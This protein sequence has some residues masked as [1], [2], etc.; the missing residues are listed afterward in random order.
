MS[1]KYKFRDQTVPH[2][3]TITLVQWIDLFTR[4]KYSEFLIDQFKHCQK[5]K[6]LLIY[7]WC[8]MPSHVHMII[9]T[10]D[11]D[12]QDILRDLKT[13]TSKNLYEMVKSNKQESRREWLL[14]FFREAGKMNGNNKHIQVWQQHNHPLEMRG[15]SKIQRCVDYI[16]MNPVV[17][18]YV[19]RPEN[20]KWSSA[21]NYVEGRRDGL[22]MLEELIY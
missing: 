9:G 14:R 12:M 10:C 19:L 3:I 16:H 17:A 21:R 22:I 6:G 2:F 13:F 5:H 18:G 7:A 1:R 11:S 20:W 8:I 4:T 15:N